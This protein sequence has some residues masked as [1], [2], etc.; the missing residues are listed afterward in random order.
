MIVMADRGAEKSISKHAFINKLRRLA[1][2]LEQDDPFLVQVKGEK[3]YVPKKA[4]Y[5]LGYSKKE[6]NAFDLCVKWK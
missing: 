1:D 4:T 6:V 3:A 5:H 2:A